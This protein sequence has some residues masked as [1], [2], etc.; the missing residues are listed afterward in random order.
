[1]KR[2]FLSFLTAIF[3]FCVL[4]APAMA[5]YE[6]ETKSQI[7]LYEDGSYAVITSYVGMSARSSTGDHK[8]YTYYNALRQECF[9]Y[10][11]YADFTYNGTTSQADSCDY[12]VKI[13][14]RGWEIDTHS[15][16][17]SGNTAYGSA[18]FTS[19]EGQARTV[20]L[21]LTCDKNGNVR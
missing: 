2:L 15:E 21:T 9:K 4:S 20:S 11:L 5:F 8:D 19:P 7:I 18:S 12:S 13:Y 16:Y 10:T 1:M 6:T 14:R 17:T 3:M